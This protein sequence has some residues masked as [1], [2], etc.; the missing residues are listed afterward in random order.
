MAAP[1]SVEALALRRGLRGSGS[2]GPQ[3][4]R[5]GMGPRRSAASARR[6][7]GDAA[8]LAVAGVAGALRPGFHPGDVVVAREIVSES[9]RVACP[10]APL[11]VGTA[12]RSGLTAHSGTVWSAPTLVHGAERA[13]LT[14]RGADVVD[15]ESAT[16]A[17][18]VGDSPLVCARVIVDTPRRPLLG[19]WTVPG[20]I[21]ALRSLRSLAPTLRFWA[22]ALGP[23][24]L[25]CAPESADLAAFARE[26]DVVLLTGEADS[27]RITHVADGAGV[28]ETPV[29][30]V[31]G[32]ESISLAW[33]EGIGDIGLVAGAQAP[34]DLEDELA[35][36]LRGLGPLTVRSWRDA[37]ETTER[38]HGE[39]VCR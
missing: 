28:V 18:A 10:A 26:V 9:A 5:T 15:M 11:V 12:R 38:T 29:Y 27:D 24:T 19:P 21:A 25:V 14:A 23:H 39:E 13:R 31:D 34:R 32:A 30:R 3:V 8:G 1:L 20:G 2:R 4:R 37:T 17:A 6:W 35:G 7:C 36:A 22:A 16:F 33:L